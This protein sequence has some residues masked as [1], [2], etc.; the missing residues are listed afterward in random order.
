[1]SYQN[2]NSPWVL[3]L[4]LV[5]GG[6]AGTW[7]GEVFSQFLPTWLLLKETVFIGLPPTTLDLNIIQFTFGFLLKLNMMTIFGFILA[8]V[9]YRW[10]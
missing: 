6:L 4:L 3:G 8:L 9:V 5:I 1:M 10:L 7:F 2:N